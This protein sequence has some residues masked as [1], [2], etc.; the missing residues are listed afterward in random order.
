MKSYFIDFH[1]Y[2]KVF[3]NSREEAEK[4]YDKLVDKWY[5]EKFFIDSAVYVDGIEEEDD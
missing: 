1:G 2:L 3:A 5:E 4:A